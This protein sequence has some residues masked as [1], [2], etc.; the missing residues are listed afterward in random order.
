[1]A[2]S[3]VTAL[4]LKE[5]KWPSL[6][7][8]IQLFDVSAWL[9]VHGSNAIRKNH[10][11]SFRFATYKAIQVWTTGEPNVLIYLKS[12]VHSG[13]RCSTQLPSSSL[14]SCWNTMG[15]YKIPSDF[16]LITLPK[17]F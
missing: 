2:E 5:H 17:Y 6:R 16:I 13:L 3:F 10:W 14:S 9:V 8:P 4:G 1:M 11:P 15:S 12:R 7:I